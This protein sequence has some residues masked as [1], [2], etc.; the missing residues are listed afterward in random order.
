MAEAKP[1]RLN[2]VEKD[3]DG[4]AFDHVPGLRS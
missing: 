1:N 4:A 2:L 3:Y